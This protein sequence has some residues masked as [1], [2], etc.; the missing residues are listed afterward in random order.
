MGQMAV[1]SRGMRSKPILAA[2]LSGQEL[3][4]VLTDRWRPRYWQDRMPTIKLTCRVQNPD[5]PRAGRVEAHGGVAGRGRA[6]LDAN[7]TVRLGDNPS[8]YP[9]KHRRNVA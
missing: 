2:R 9:P 7:R 8:S 6:G 1:L 5:I 4:L 3:E